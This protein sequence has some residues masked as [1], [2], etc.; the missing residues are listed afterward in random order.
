MIISF[1]AILMH[2]Q[3]SSQSPVPQSAYANAARFADHYEID[4]GGKAALQ[5]LAAA[6]AGAKVALVGKIGDDHYGKNMLLKLRQRGVITSGVGRNETIPTGI[7]IEIGGK[8]HDRILALG[9]SQWADATQIPE[10]ILKPDGFLLLQTE[11][12]MKQNTLMFEKA[13][14]CGAKTILNLSPQTELTPEDMARIDYLITPAAHKGYVADAARYKDLILIVLDDHGGLIAMKAGQVIAE[15]ELPQAKPD[16]DSNPKDISFKYPSCSEEA[17]CGTFA[18]A[19]Y[20]QMPLEEA[21]K[22]A[23]A[24]RA[25]TASKKGGYKTMPYLDTLNQLFKNN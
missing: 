24:A 10:E 2:L 11:I 15:A 20:N 14:D 17:F 8:T 9:A 23:N 3:V 5:A 22:Y 12:A 13:R 25:L 4:I 18:A 21:L 7:C 1:G 16:E 6:N 19:L